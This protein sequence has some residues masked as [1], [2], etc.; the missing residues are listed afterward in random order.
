L[1]QQLAATRA[2]VA[3]A[4]GFAG[5]VVAL[6]QLVEGVEGGQVDHAAFAEVWTYHQMQQRSG[7]HIA[8]V[9]VRVSLLR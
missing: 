9:C 4:L 2:E 3:Q 6:G 5:T 1:S 7:K 8:S